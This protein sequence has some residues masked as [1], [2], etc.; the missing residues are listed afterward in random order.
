LLQRVI[1][2]YAK[3]TSI[4]AISDRRLKHDIRPL[5]SDLGLDFI[6]KL[7]AVAYRFNDGDETERYGF[8]GQDLEA[9]LPSS[10]HD[11]ERPQP[12]H[13]VALIE[14]QGDKDPCCRSS[15]SFT[16]ALEPSPG[17]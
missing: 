10:L 3:V 14:R 8:L 5:A 1:K 7:K 4:T 11:I 2:I 16:R 9:A 17:S 13:G 6:A 12:E 15:R